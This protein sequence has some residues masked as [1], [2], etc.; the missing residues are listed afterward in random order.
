MRKRVEYDLKYMETWT[1]G[2]DM[3]IIGKTVWNMIRGEKNAY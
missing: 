1:F 2:L 3:K